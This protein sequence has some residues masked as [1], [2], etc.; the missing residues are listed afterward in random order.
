MANSGRIVTIF[1]I[2][3]QSFQCCVKTRSHT[4]SINCSKVA[5]TFTSPLTYA[6]LAGCIW[7][8][9]HLTVATGKVHVL[10]NHSCLQHVPYQQRFYFLPSASL[11]LD[12]LYGCYANLLYLK[13]FLWLSKVSFIPPVASAGGWPLMTPSVQLYLPAL[14]FIPAGGPLVL[15]SS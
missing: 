13:L 12:C 11:G 10:L 4:C 15:W 1:K 9:Y 3:C 5:G 8:Y 2:D 7:V 14:Q 6:G